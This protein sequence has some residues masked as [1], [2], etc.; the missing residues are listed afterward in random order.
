MD[1]SILRKFLSSRGLT[2]NDYMQFIEQHNPNDLR[3]L[4][5]NLIEQNAKESSF[6]N[7]FINIDEFI[8]Y[9]RILK[10]YSQEFFDLCTIAYDLGKYISEQFYNEADDEI[11][12]INKNEIRLVLNK[13]ALLKDEGFKLLE[14]KEVNNSKIENVIEEIRNVSLLKNMQEIPLKSKR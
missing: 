14:G 4:L 9:C 3:K 10:L 6:Y 12:K 2:A 7:L 13:I 5:D 11:S 1:N 8:S